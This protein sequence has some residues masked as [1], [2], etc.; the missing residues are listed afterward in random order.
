MFKNRKMKRDDATRKRER[1]R[2]RFFKWSHPPAFFYSS[3]VSHPPRPSEEMLDQFRIISQTE[4][5]SLSK[6][7]STRESVSVNCKPLHF[8]YGGLLSAFLSLTYARS[9]TVVFINDTNLR[10][11]QWRYRE[12][13]EAAGEREHVFALPDARLRWPPAYYTS[14]FLQKGP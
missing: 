5:V 8:S 14:A 4:T 7:T 1:E 9:R 2:E 3:R 12:D 6:S 11:P 10:K 13:K